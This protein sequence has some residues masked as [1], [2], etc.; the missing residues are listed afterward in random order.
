LF[1]CI[2]AHAWIVNGDDD[3]ADAIDIYSGEDEK[4]VGL[5]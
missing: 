3:A 4:I 1:V 2:I 5:N